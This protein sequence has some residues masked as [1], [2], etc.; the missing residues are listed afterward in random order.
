MNAGD[1]TADSWNSTISRLPGANLLQTW[2]WAQLKST[3]GWEADP[4]VWRDDRGE[5]C[6]AAMVLRRQLKLRN[7][8]PGLS[9]MYVPRGPLLDWSSPE[10]RARVMDDLQLLAR[11]TGSIFIKI[12]PD[13]RIGVGV[14]GVDGSQNDEVGLAAQGELVRRGWRFSEEQIQFRNTVILDLEGGED[15]WLARMKQKARYNK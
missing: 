14:P 8:R 12:D 10:L 5:V 11:R 15:A 3:I 6:A 1:F 4:R 7:I 2:E 9:V 13:L